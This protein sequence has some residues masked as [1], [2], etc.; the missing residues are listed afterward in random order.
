MLIC[1]LQWKSSVSVQQI[2]TDNGNV[3]LSCN[4]HL[5]KD[6]RNIFLC[7]GYYWIS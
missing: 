4:S 7:Y 6:G 3:L 2:S 5:I 1:F